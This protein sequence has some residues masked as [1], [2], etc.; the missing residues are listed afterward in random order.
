[1]DFVDIVVTPQR[2]E[3]KTGHN[4]SRA[5][6]MVLA[7]TTLVARGPVLKVPLAWPVSSHIWTLFNNSTIKGKLSKRFYFT[8]VQQTVFSSH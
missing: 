5:T 7:T 8:S 3:C 1:V 2:L 6:A 4:R